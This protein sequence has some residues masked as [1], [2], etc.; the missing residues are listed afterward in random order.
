MLSGMRCVR[1]RAWRQVC[2]CEHLL[3]VFLAQLALVL[4]IADTLASFVN[5]VFSPLLDL[6]LISGNST[7]AV[8]H[9]NEA[10]KL[11]PPI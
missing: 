6:V 8:A 4:A 11:A 1:A 3:A 9:C 2:L 5:V 10:S 7:L